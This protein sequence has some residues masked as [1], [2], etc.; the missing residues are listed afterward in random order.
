MKRVLVG[1]DIGG[2]KIAV[3]ARETRSERE[4]YSAK[5]K[6]PADEGLG[7]V[8]RLIDEQVDAL[9]G[10][11][12]SMAAMGIAVPGAV[13]ENGHVLYAGNL[14]GWGDVPL[15][16]QLEERYGVP[17]YVER[18]ANCGAVGEKWLGVAKKMKDFVFLALGTGV[19]AGLFIDG[20]LYRGAHYAAGEVGDMTFLS[21]DEDTRLSDVVGKRE[22]KKKAKKATG[23]K[24]SAA[25]VLERAEKI[26][27][28][29]PVARDVVEHLSTSVV[30]ISSLLDPEAIV[31]GGGT[32]QAGEPLLKMVRERVAPLHVVRARLMLGELGSSAQLYGALWGA[33]RV[34][35]RRQRQTPIPATRRAKTGSR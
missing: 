21:E 13:D 23:K 14:R 3:L 32:S 9:P 7:A 27:A 20:S 6:T 4:V 8:L 18:D 12:S 2:T 35:R 15:R 5:V 29:R 28:L 17:V 33:Q 19:G 16:E 25:E 30:A 34:S 22:I 11:R 26:R 24:M 10:G 31:F 1:I